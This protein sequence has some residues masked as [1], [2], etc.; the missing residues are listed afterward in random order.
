[1][2]A[3]VRV[4]RGRVINMMREDVREGP[5]AALL[6]PAPLVSVFCFLSSSTA[7]SSE[8]LTL[9]NTLHAFCHGFQKQ[10]ISTLLFIW[11]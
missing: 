6:G 9:P 1:M 2:T 7:T 4:E 8:L 11:N 10:N 3:A 5:I